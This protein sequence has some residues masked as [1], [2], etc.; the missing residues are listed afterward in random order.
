MAWW[1]AK[2]IERR[3][4]PR[5]TLGKPM[6]E[7]TKKLLSQK[8]KEAWINNEDFRASSLTSL[9]AGRK[10]NPMHR[11]GVAARVSAIQKGRYREDPNNTLRASSKALLRHHVSGSFIATLK[12]ILTPAG[13]QPEYPIGNRIADFAHLEAKIIVECDGP[14]HKYPCAWKKDQVRD[15]YLNK[16][17][18]RVIHV[19][20]D[21]N[22]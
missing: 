17:G 11:P 7:S 22:G 1:N 14:T 13:F 4:S 21:R 15:A 19:A 3:I 20:E 12:D 6:S 2:D 18:W 5:P 16:L 9:A 10:I 8:V